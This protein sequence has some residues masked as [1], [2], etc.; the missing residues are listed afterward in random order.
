LLDQP[1]LRRTRQERLAIL[2]RQTAVRGLELGVD[3]AQIV[4]ALK[5]ELAV[6]GQASPPTTPTRRAP[7]SRNPAA[8]DAQSMRGT[9]SAVRAGEMLDEVTLD[10]A[11]AQVGAA[12]TRASLDRLQ[13][14][15][16]AAQ[17]A[18][19]VKAIVVTLGR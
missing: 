15:S 1:E 7:R 5:A 3:A 6:H 11:S 19:Y 2:V 16:L 9:V 17:A 12:I 14:E 18:A 13:L 10:A 4:D 8:V